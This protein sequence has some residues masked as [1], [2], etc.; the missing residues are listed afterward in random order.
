MIVAGDE[1]EHPP[2]VKDKE[3]EKKKVVL[4]G[5]LTVCK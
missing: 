2:H 1:D 3:K 5:S 4:K